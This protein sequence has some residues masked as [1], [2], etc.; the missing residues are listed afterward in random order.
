MA[1]LAVA[2]GALAAGGWAAA[3]ARPEA[4]ALAA[5]AAFVFT[6]GGNALNDYFDRDVDR[7]NH[8]D[9]PLPAGH[10]TPRAAFGLSLTLFAFAFPL[11]L[12]VNVVA[13]AVVAANLVVLVA[14]E[15]AFKAR[16]GSGNVVIGWLVGSLFLFGGA[17]VYVGDPTPLLRAGLLGLLAA[18]ATVGREI[19]KDIEDVA[20]DVD[21]RTLPR[22][23]GVARAG[24]LAAGFFLA[25]VVLS[26]LPFLVAVMGWAYVAVVIPADATF[27]YS[28]TYST[29]KPRAAARLAK[30]GMVLALLAFLAG[31]LVP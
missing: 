28:A 29:R 27:I 2:L 31:A 30:A 14:Y 23:W 24:H 12:F 8:P 17:A 5:A 25:A 19:V 4:V 26:S 6:G 22:R 3:A 13:V 10:V 7:V 1:A 16:G 15:T 9:R 21:R 20:G 11:A 18:L